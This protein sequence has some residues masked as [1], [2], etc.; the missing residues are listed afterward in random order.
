MAS[1]TGVRIL[2]V[3]D[4]FLLAMDMEAALSQEGA[5]VIGPLVTVPDAV[6]AAEIEDLAGAVL[7]LN[8][9]GQMSYPIASVLERRGIPFLFATGYDTA[10]LA[11]KF[12]GRPCLRKPFTGHALTAALRRLLTAKPH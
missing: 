7:D 4:E 9:R 3:E 5:Q 8:L 6:K 11:R 1:L 10:R 12:R 2:L